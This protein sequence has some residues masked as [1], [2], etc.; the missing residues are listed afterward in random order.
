MGT[1]IISIVI[2]LVVANVLSLFVRPGSKI[3]GLKKTRVETDRERIAREVIAHRAD[4]KASRP[5][6]QQSGRPLRQ[7]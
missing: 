2:F 1:L 4:R 6:P 7:G 5:L 3:R